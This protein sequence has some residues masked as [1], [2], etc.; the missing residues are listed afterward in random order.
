MHCEC[1]Y[2]LGDTDNSCELMSFPSQIKTNCTIIIVHFCLISGFKPTSWLIDLLILCVI[3]TSGW[4]RSQT[5]SEIWLH[6]I[7]SSSNKLSQSA[8][9]QRCS[10]FHTFKLQ[11]CKTLVNENINSDLISVE[12]VYL[13]WVKFSQ[14]EMIKH[15]ICILRSTFSI[16]NSTGDR[17]F[18]L[19]LFFFWNYSTLW[20]S[21][22]FQ[23]Q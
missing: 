22:I 11:W 12:R 16:S 13:T 9:K 10:A 14:H 4:T 1:R 8:V 3:L 23:S 18:L 2:L 20:S 17:V 15:I 21:Y 5:G 6:V 19:I 7:C